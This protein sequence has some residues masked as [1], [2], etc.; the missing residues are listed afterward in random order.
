MAEL[1][2]PK[3]TVAHMNGR[4]KLG[5]EK[6]GLNGGLWVSVEPSRGGRLLGCRPKAARLLTPGSGHFDP[7]S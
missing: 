5:S 4:Q 2:A 7:L 3:S 6:D 1:G